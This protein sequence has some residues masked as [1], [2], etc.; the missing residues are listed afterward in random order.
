MRKKQHLI[1]IDLDGTLL[2]DNKQISAHTKRMIKQIIAEGHIVVIATGRANRTSIEYYY[3]LGLTTPLINSNGAVIHHPLNKNWGNYHTPLKHETALDIIDISYELKS[4]N[5]LA[6][7]HDSVFLDRF[8][9]QIV[10]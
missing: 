10:D 9:Q 7:V 1:A 8:D 2:M 6:T 4:E 3:E 5:I